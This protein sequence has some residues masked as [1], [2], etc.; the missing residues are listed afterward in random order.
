MRVSLDDFVN[1]LDPARATVEMFSPSLHLETI[2]AVYD[3]GTVLWRAD[4]T[5]THVASHVGDPDVVVQR[6]DPDASA[7]GFRG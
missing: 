4:I 7:L 5:M 1:T 2:D 6:V 3:S